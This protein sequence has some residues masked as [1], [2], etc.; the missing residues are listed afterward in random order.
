MKISG[1]FGFGTHSSERASPDNKK[2]PSRARGVVP[3]K[4]SDR[5]RFGCPTGAGLHARLQAV[6]SGLKLYL[7]E[8]L[9]LPRRIALARI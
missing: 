6:L 4:V 1:L 8:H 9:S 3:T 2:K 7:Q 5:Q